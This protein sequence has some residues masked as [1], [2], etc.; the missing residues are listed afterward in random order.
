MQLLIIETHLH[1]WHEI[2]K[3][4]DGY[5]SRI[6][7]LEALGAG[8]WFH[9]QVASGHTE[10][11]KNL[12]TVFMQDLLNRVHR[13]WGKKRKIIDQKPSCISCLINMNSINKIQSP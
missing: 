11:R 13:T 2:T 12:E 4:F 10:R 3:C 8:A 5:W 1:L 7:V 6:G 9:K